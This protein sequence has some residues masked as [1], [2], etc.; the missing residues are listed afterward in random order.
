[1]CLQTFDCWCMK[2]HPS[3]SKSSTSGKNDLYLQKPAALGH[4]K[5]PNVCSDPDV[6]LITPSDHSSEI[7]CICSNYN[8]I[9]TLYKYV[10]I[11]RFECNENDYICVFYSQ[12]FSN[13]PQEFL[14]FQTKLIFL[15]TSQHSFFTNLMSLSYRK[16]QLLAT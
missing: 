2:E 11:V 10:K 7:F 1:M 9:R 4:A 6:A 14:P 15:K 13:V 5:V 16:K 3:A 8:Q 12:I